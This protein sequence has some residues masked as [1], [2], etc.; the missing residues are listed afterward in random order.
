MRKILIISA[1]FHP[2]IGGLEGYNLELAKELTENGYSITIVTNNTE[3]IEIC[4]QFEGIKIY[5]I[6][7]YMMIFNNSGGLPFPK[8]NKQSFRLLKQ[9]KQDNYNL[10]IT[11]TRFFTL[12]HLI[13]YYLNYPKQKVIHIEHGSGNVE[14]NNKF[15]NVLSN[16]YDW[17][18]IN[19]LKPKVG[20]FF[21]VSNQCNEFLSNYGIEPKGL[22]KSGINFNKNVINK[23]NFEII[24]LTFVGRI[25]NDKGIT[26][27][28][29]AFTKLNKQ[30]LILNIVGDGP[31]YHELI[32]SYGDAKNI[33]FYGS[34]S[35]DRVRDILA[36]THIFI[37]P[38]YAKEGGQRSILEAGINKCAVITTDVGFVPD[39]ITN[40]SNGLIIE[41]KSSE[42][43]KIKIEYLVNNT[44]LI[45][46]YGNKLFEVI[47]QNFSW[48]VNLEIINNIIANNSKSLPQD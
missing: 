42:D 8:L 4:E 34:L 40:Y 44:N 3:N 20:C 35:S 45:N 19:L 22:L 7:N 24:Y 11:N 32:Q 37:N 21:G 27:L 31:L 38:S 29:D 25:I 47:S 10:I 46:S 23:M 6:P 15:L 33:I 16:F 13:L 36:E 41:K 39:L 14:L 28:L 12:N 18:L 1:F 26:Y 2:H 30:N 17:A 48:K 9:I 43:I 5:R